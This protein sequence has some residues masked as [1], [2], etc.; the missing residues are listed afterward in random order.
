MKYGAFNN[1]N[2]DF[3]AN[4]SEDFDEQIFKPD[5]YYYYYFVYQQKFTWN[6]HIQLMVI[7]QNLTGQWNQNL[8]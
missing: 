7:N 1:E 3:F 6:G 4:L 2:L 8:I 5:Y